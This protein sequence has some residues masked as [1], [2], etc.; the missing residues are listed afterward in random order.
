[1]VNMRTDNESSE[2]RIVEAAIAHVR[3]RLLLALALR[4]VLRALILGSIQ[5]CLLVMAL[6]LAGRHSPAAIIF[7]G[8][9]I[10][11]PVIGL[12]MRR[13]DRWPESAAGHFPY[14][15]LK[16][17]WLAAVIRGIST[18]WEPF[19]WPILI[20]T[21]IG[22]G[23]VLA[24]GWFPVPL[25]LPA[26]MI[27][28]LFVSVALA[29]VPNVTFQ[30]AALFLD[31]RANL[32]ERLST[33]GE[34]DCL[35]D[36]TA[37]ELEKQLRHETLRQAASRLRG[38]MDR[39]WYPTPA[40]RRL[41]GAACLGIATLFVSTL[42][43]QRISPTSHAC[44]EPGGTALRSRRGAIAAPAQTATT[45]RIP[46]AILHR[47]PEKMVRRISTMEK[48]PARRPPSRRRE[49]VVLARLR[50]LVRRELEKE[51]QARLSLRREASL[52]P[53]IPH[54]SAVPA[55]RDDRA[56]ISKI[57]PSS[58]GRGQVGL[59]VPARQTGISNGLGKHNG[60]SPGEGTNS[61][62]AAKA[63][64]SIDAQP[65]G[66][67]AGPGATELTA[68]LMKL[69]ALR[70][71]DRWIKTDLSATSG[72]QAGGQ[73][74]L[75]PQPGPL[76]KMI[77]RK[78]RKNGQQ[79]VA[80]QRLAALLAPVYRNSSSGLTDARLTHR[81][82]RDDN[83]RAFHGDKGSGETNGPTASPNSGGGGPPVQASARASLVTSD[84]I[85]ILRVPA[86]S[87]R[88]KNESAELNLQTS[89]P[90]RSPNKTRVPKSY[91]IIVER[92]F[93]R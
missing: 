48:L 59:P 33:A 29:S 74:D 18:V 66:K 4:R 45:L 80:L 64:V 57:A 24:D 73:G 16:I 67:R 41:W 82:G 42:I 1:M 49:A 85:I 62:G 35:A 5:A 40:P 22:I 93:S 81:V 56:K 12:A 51:L 52:L 71:L 92:Y 47:L 26:I 61:A 38:G 7:I 88:D 69:A 43:A 23:F 79:L 86:Q 13:R 55:A 37:S 8:A 63:N 20:P 25:G 3:R 17:S 53:N 78:I 28:G 83:R 36:V 19:S 15:Y 31:L 44:P 54:P 2:W 10:F 30:Q 65:A 84:R 32:G 68:R 14:Q 70:G 11:W 76:R 50:K 75:A 89:L 90:R 39:H 46:S 87:P 34:S 77:N 91:R 58:T 9:T 72:V 27:P 21:T 6:A 60:G